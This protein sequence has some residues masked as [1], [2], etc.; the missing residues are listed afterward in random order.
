MKKL[1]AAH[2]RRGGHTAILPQ[3]PSAP[4]RPAF[5]ACRGQHFTAPTAT[6]VGT[7]ELL[8]TR[9]KFASISTANG[10]AIQHEPNAITS[11][12]RQPSRSRAHRLSPGRGRSATPRTAEI[13][14]SASRPARSAGIDAENTI[15]P[16]LRSTSRS[17]PLSN[18]VIRAMKPIPPRNQLR[19]RPPRRLNVP[20]ATV[21]ATRTRYTGQRAESGTRQRS[22]CSRTASAS[23]PRS[24]IAATRQHQRSRQTADECRSTRVTTHIL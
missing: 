19:D 12:K 1:P 6:A 16:V 7:S 20:V 5:V 11:S 4:Q 21:L 2:S 18:E 13:G 9:R 15:N 23:Q 22:T 3:R 14:D 17:R 8:I 24:W 10:A